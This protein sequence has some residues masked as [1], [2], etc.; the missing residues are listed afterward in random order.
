LFRRGR[1]SAPGRAAPPATGGVGP[2]WRVSARYRSL[3]HL[4]ADRAGDFGLLS[5]SALEKARTVASASA[6]R[7]DPPDASSADSL[8]GGP[9]RSD[10]S[11]GWPGGGQRR[12]NPV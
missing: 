10:R 7:Q 5:G 8:A 11:R 2:A 12:A 4:L 6:A 1:D 3:A 9:G